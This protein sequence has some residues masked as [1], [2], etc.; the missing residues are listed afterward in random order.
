MVSVII[1]AFNEGKTIANVIRAAFSHPEVSEVIVVDDGSRDTTVIES[2]RAG[3]TIF[4][5][6]RNYG[7]ATAMN[8]GVK[9]ASNSILFF[10]DADVIGLTRDMMDKAIRAV[11][12]ERSDMFV[13]ITDHSNWPKEF[14]KRMPLIGG[15]RVMRKMIWNT[16]PAHFKRRFEIE[17]ALNYFAQKNNF[18][19]NSEMI[20]GLGQV[21]KEK[22]RGVVWGL[23]QRFF[24]IRDLVLIFTKLYL[25][26]NTKLVL[27]SK[28]AYRRITH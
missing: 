28:L 11:C 18:V 23:Y 19:I 20:I 8:T 2:K 24:M 4:K 25:I 12:D 9:E 27:K 21:V 10:I 5:H 3:A 6:D 26:Y 22:K 17:V 7:K 16:V 15:I 14:M 13:L 1:P